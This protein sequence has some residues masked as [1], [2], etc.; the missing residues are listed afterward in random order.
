M[1]NPELSGAADFIIP[2]LVILISGIILTFFGSK[3]MR[4]APPVTN[5]IVAFAIFYE[6]FKDSSYINYIGLTY[7]GTVVGV[8]YCLSRRSSCYAIGSS[9]GLFFGYIAFRQMEKNADIS[10]AWKWVVLS[11]TIL[12]F[13]ILLIV[14]DKKL[15]FVYTSLLGAVFLTYG[16]SMLLSSN[17]LKS[18]Y[19][20]D[21]SESKSIY[22]TVGNVVILACG[23]AFQ[24]F[25]FKR[26]KK[27]S[28]AL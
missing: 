27:Q 8:I 7:I 5:T 13:A 16:I 24:F 17:Y 23:L 15:D 14:L 6:A 3:L 1:V 20:F 19:N 4:L 10:P 21:F 28:H 2:C 11:V 22:L 26:G 12:V 18:I 9:V 25:L